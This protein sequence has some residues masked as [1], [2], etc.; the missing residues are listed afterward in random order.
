MADTDAELTARILAG[1]DAA[2]YELVRRYER[3]VFNLV[4][5]IVRDAGLAE[6]LA[7]DTFLKAFTRLGTYDPSFKFSNWILKIAHNTAIDHVRR[8]QPPATVLDENDAAGGLDSLKSPAPGPQLLAERRE[9]AHAFDE[10]IDELRPEYRELVVLRYHEDLGYEEIADIL[11]LPVGTVKSY[12]HRARAE[13]AETL[14]RAGWGGC[15][16][17]RR[18]SVGP[19]GRS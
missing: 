8:G 7:Q 15:N 13:L 2:A 1:S 9:L 6:D 5:R 11:D 14:R 17:E 18:V 10:A 3:P 19:R 16:T 4:V 12:L